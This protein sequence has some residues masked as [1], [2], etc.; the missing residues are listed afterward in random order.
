MIELS[1][2]QGFYFVALHGGYAKAARAF[3]YP[4]S[5]PGVYRQVQRLED[6]LGVELFHRVDRDTVAPT[7]EGRA[8]LAFCAPFFEQLP[9]VL[10]SI[11]DG[12][13]GGVLRLE[14]APLPLR[15]FVP[16]WIARIK[17]KRPDIELSI[18][19]R[20]NPEIGRLRSMDADLIVDFVAR[21]P[22]GIELRTIARHHGFIVAPRERMRS[23]TRKADLTAFADEPFIAYQPGSPEHRG[24]LFAL[25]RAGLEP[26]PS[27]SVSSTE[28]I[29]AMVGSGLG[30]SLIA[31]PDP[32]GPRHRGVLAL[33]L[34]KDAPTIP[35][36]VAYRQGAD[37]DPL[38]CA[39]L[40]LL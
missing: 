30:Y 14:V 17:R 29:L 25:I 7:S 16:P 11:T 38:V 9:S 39:A 33:P 22:Q 13:F 10:R 3:P 27:L 12:R 34:G 8:L 6:E 23:R 37:K 35:I 5:Q 1:R 31:W 19:E 24:Q 20:Q 36:S 40:E 21:A 32:R 28:A 15:H 18:E 4:I 26:T 2:L